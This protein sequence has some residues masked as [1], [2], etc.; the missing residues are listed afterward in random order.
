[1]A[2]L[3]VAAQLPRVRGARERGGVGRQVDHALHRVERL[4][5]APQ[6]EQRIAEGAVEQRAVRVDVETELRLGERRVEVVAGR[7]E[8]RQPRMGEVVALAED[9][10]R[11]SQRAVR[12]RVVARVHVHLCLLH[13]GEPERGPG[14]V[15]ARGGLQPLLETGD[16]VV[17]ARAGRVAATGEL[18]GDG[19]RR[20]RRRGATALAVAARADDAEGARGE[21]HGAADQSGED[22]STTTA[23]ARGRRSRSRAALVGDSG[24]GAAELRLLHGVAAPSQEP[25]TVPGNQ[26]ARSTTRSVGC[27]V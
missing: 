25:T 2:A 18:G 6:L 9:V 23:T 7:G 3:D 15:V 10:Q 11:G 12:Q 8:S 20:R 1:M 13:V 27:E 24:G 22:Q 17:E 14:D 16:H 19:D 21:Q 5:V 26:P 4:V